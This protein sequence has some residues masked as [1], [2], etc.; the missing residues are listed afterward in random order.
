MASETSPPAARRIDRAA[1]LLRFYSAASAD[2][3]P[4]ADPGARG[5]EGELEAE[6]EQLGPGHPDRAL[7]LSLLGEAA[8]MRYATGGRRDDLYRALEL[9]KRGVA[10][11]EAGDPLRP[12][13]LANVAD[14]RVK[15]FETSRDRDHLVLAVDLL[16][17]ALT[18]LPDGH[19][20]RVRVL[21]LLAVALAAL[22]R[23]RRDADALREAH[24]VLASLIDDLHDADPRKAGVLLLY[25]SVLED[26]YLRDRERSNLERA[27][28]AVHQALACAHAYDL[29]IPQCHAKLRALQQALAAS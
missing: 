4:R 22:G 19:Q 12:R 18:A 1:V 7:L 16:R 3:T 27:V 23:E 14:A 13:L 9:N 26:R 2:G 8:K 5:R 15:S 17:E 28:L 6:L 25:A 20:E 29:R 10:S 11:A 21:S 24:D